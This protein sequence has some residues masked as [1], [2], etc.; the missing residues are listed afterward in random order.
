[1]WS[2]VFGTS[3]SGAYALLL[4]L[5]CGYPM[6]TKITSDLYG[7]GRISRREAEYL[8]TFTNH[9]SPVFIYTYLIHICLNDRF[10]PRLIYGPLILASFLTM[11]I[12]RFFVYRNHT[13][14]PDNFSDKK[15]KEPSAPGVTGT[16]LDASIMNGFE[17]ITRLG[18]YILLFSI[19]SAFIRHYW[20]AGEM[21][22]YLFLGALEL[23][24]GLHQLARSGF[25]PVLRYLCSM[26]MAAFGGVCILAQTKSLL[27]RD[28]SVLPYI[29]AKCLNAAITA[30]CALVFLKVV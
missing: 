19:L 26:P 11:V 5:L 2:H 15:N 13:K 21:T 10:H 3:P 9:A 18:G 12:F 27:H 1:M 24:T 17:T 4:G 25:S 30:I 14:T 7:C 29:S 22:E 16:L 8:L 20:S 28:L 23:T 6:G